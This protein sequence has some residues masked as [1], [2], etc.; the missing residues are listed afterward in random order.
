[1]VKITTLGMSVV[2]SGHSRRLNSSLLSRLNVQTIIERCLVLS[3]ED[4]R[5]KDPVEKSDLARISRCSRG[6]G[7]GSEEMLQLRV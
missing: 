6:S 7:Y 4:R 5:P 3:E 2:D 1:M